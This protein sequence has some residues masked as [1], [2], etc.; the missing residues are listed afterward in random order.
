MFVSPALQRGVRFF[1]IE[2][3]SRRDDD[4]PL[5][6]YKTLVVLDSAIAEKN[7][8]L[9]FKVAFA[10]MFLLAL[11]VFFHNRN[12]RR[13]N[14]ERAVSFLP[15]K[16]MPHPPRGASLELLNGL[17][18][19][20]GRRQD[21]EQMDVIRRSAGGD[22]REALAMGYAAQVGIKLGRTDCG[23]ERAPIFRAENTMNEIAR[24]CMRHLTPSLRDSH[25]T[26][27]IS[28]PTLKRWAN[29]HCAYGA[30]RC[31]LR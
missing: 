21:K 10:V 29:K 14:T 28:I 3:E 31:V 23:N 18:E 30:C 15:G 19:G 25:S 17:G 4:R 22:Q 8:K 9:L 13:A 5:P 27:A 1:A 20:V 6:E 12:L 7:D 26:T 2:I 16:T 11:N 24:V